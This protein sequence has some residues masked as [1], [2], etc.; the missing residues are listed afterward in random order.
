VQGLALTDEFG[1]FQAELE[2]GTDE[3]HV[4]TRTGSCDIA[5]PD[6]QATQGVA[7]VGVLLCQLQTLE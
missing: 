2:Q 7:S 3:L 6:Y 5:V 1:L 4:K